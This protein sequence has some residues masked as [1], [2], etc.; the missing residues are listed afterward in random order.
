MVVTLAAY[1]HASITTAEHAFKPWFAFV[2]FLAD[3]AI[4]G[5]IVPATPLG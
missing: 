2:L 1:V 3:L 5:A 4:A